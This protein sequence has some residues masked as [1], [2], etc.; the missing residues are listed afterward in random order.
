MDKKQKEALM[1]DANQVALLGEKIGYGHLMSL[2]SALWRK[3]LQQKGYPTSG[4]FV[5][6][7]LSFIKKEEQAHTQKSNDHYDQIIKPCNQ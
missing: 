7:I 1:E 5:P 4:A 2:A 3:H 6:T